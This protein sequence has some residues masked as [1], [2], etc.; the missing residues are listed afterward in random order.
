MFFDKQFYTFYFLLKLLRLI[1]HPDD[2]CHKK[3]FACK[4]NQFLHLI[5]PFII[6]CFYNKDSKKFVIPFFQ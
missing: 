3:D 4:Y 5:L 1:I 6:F 2:N